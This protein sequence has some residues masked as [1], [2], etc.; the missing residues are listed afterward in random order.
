MD[1]YQKDGSVLKCIIGDIKNQD[2]AG[3]NKWGH[4]NGECIIEFVVNGSTWYHNGSGSHSNP[5]TASCHPEWNQELTKAVNRG[6]YWRS[7]PVTED[8]KEDEKE[9]AATGT[10]TE[11]QQ[12]VAN[13]AR[14]GISTITATLVVLR[15][16]YKKK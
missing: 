16:T 13:N 10:V 7:E 1:F 15:L 14:N 9:P 11:K 2:D 8:K 12:L 4:M 3:C 6:N 5:G